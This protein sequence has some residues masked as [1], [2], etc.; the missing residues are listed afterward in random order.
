MKKKTKRIKKAKYIDAIATPINPLT[1]KSMWPPSARMIPIEAL[2]E[3]DPALRKKL[4][5]ATDRLLAE[6]TKHTPSK[7]VRKKRV[8]KIGLD[9]H[10]V[11]TETP[12]F[13]AILSQTMVDAGHEVHILT[14]PPITKQ[15][16][17]WLT[18]LGIKWTH[19]FSIVDHHRAIGTGIWQDPKSGYWFTHDWAWDKTKADYCAEHGIELHIDDSERYNYFFKTP[20][21][22][23]QSRKKPWKP[24]TKETK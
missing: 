3:Q 10:G 24:P 4:A 23:Y 13:W 6:A 14:G 18:K 9:I 8:I 15:F 21:A 12:E 19:I 11:I 16:T 5:R 22:R 20:Y 17:K 7:T 2:F 1:G